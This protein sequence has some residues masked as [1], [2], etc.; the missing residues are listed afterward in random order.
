MS[1]FIAMCVTAVLIGAF[2]IGFSMIA[3]Y[4]GFDWSES[5]MDIG[6]LIELTALVIILISICAYF[7]Y[8]IWRMI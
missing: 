3:E 4:I 1:I 6:I 8:S 2:L 7:V 5:L